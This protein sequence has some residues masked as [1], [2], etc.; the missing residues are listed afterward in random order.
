YSGVGHSARK[1]WATRRMCL[2]AQPACFGGRLEGGD[3]GCGHPTLVVIE[4]NVLFDCDRDA[5]VDHDAELTV[6]CDRIEV[7]VLLRR[8]WYQVGNVDHPSAG[9]H[10]S[11][12]DRRRA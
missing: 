3:T 11:N 5:R 9:C 8:R 2:V 1:G 4:E 6:G 12:D 10:H 7:D